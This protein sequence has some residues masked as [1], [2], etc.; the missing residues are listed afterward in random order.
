M[1]Y[2]TPAQKGEVCKVAE[3]ATGTVKTAM[4]AL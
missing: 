1:K 2:Y 3:L 4:F